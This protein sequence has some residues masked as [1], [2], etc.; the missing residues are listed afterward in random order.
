MLA[1]CWGRLE[2]KERHP[3]ITYTMV[4]KSHAEK[5]RGIHF[6]QCVFVEVSSTRHPGLISFH[7]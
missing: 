6:V 5:R 3:E 4:N 1:R 2:H 7:H